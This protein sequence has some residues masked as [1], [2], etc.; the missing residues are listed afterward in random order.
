[1]ENKGIPCAKIF[2]CLAGNWVVA[3]CKKQYCQT[4]VP[5]W[6]TVERAWGHAGVQEAACKSG[7]DKMQ[8]QMLKAEVCE[9][10]SN[11]QL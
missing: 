7:L 8:L 4:A 6:L 2:V 9:R 3:V 10:Y 1:M 5:L 11:A